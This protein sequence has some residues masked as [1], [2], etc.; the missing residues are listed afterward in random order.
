[1]DGH[2]IQLGSAAWLNEPGFQVPTFSGTVGSSSLIAIDSQL[3]G[4]FVLANALRPEADALLQR[5]AH[6]CELA[7][8]SGDNERERETFRRLFGPNAR[9]RFNQS[10]LEKLEFIRDL[11]VSGRTVMMVGDGLN[12]AGALRQS[13]VGVAV[14]ERIGAFSPASDIILEA[15]QVPRLVR[16]MALARKSVLIV[17]SSFV[18][19]GLY[20]LVG[21]S[22]AAAGVLSP[23]ICAVLM[24]LSSV[25]VVLFA[26]G[27]TAWAAKRS[28][29]CR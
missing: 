1:V 17:R 27:A 16:I 29:T 19:S 11:Q 7:L 20:N 12:D 8:L 22:I 24:P 9:L 15:A 21:I 26:C 25:S 14:V 6:H 10:P 28:E 4:G 23:I 18:I 13:E 2:R 3:R 5:L